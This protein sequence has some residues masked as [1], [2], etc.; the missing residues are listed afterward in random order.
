MRTRPSVGARGPERRSE[1]TNTEH[2]GN[3]NGN[4]DGNGDGNGEG[5]GEGEG[6]MIRRGTLLGRGTTFTSRGHL[7]GGS[8]P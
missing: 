2:G 8:S 3:G 4:G 5:E 7:R 6:E 1:G